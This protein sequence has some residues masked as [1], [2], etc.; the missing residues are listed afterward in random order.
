MFFTVVKA[1]VGSYKIRCSV[2]THFPRSIPNEYQNKTI[3]ATRFS[4]IKPMYCNSVFI[5]KKSK[6]LTSQKEKAEMK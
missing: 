6:S 2:R 1:S 5:C 3:F 4:R